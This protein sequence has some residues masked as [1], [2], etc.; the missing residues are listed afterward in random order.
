MSSEFDS[1]RNSFETFFFR[2]NLSKQFETTFWNKFVHVNSLGTQT[3]LGF[4]SRV[5][6]KSPFLADSNF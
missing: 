1:E 4:E 2:S 3:F 5:C 6:R